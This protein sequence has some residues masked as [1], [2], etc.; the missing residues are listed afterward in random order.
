M[1][2]STTVRIKARIAEAFLQGTTDQAKAYGKKLEQCGCFSPGVDSMTSGPYLSLW[3]Y[4]ARAIN[5][6][7]SAMHLSA[8]MILLIKS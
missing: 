1:Y 4:P 8:K 3:G 7:G 5:A 2:M 6:S